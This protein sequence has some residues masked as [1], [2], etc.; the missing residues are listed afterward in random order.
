VKVAHDALGADGHASIRGPI[1]G[2]GDGVGDGNAVGVAGLKLWQVASFLPQ[3][4]DVGCFAR[5]PRFPGG[6]QDA[7]THGSKRERP[8]QIDEEKCLLA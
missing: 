4:A 6:E 7:S 3:A 2:A 5:P 1:R 8:R